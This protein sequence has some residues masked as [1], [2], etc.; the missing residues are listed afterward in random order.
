MGLV[1]ML[2]LAGVFKT[3]GRRVPSLVGSIPTQSRQTRKKTR[4]NNH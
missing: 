3:L 2:V 4:S 1:V